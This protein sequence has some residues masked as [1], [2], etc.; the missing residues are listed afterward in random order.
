VTSAC[1]EKIPTAEKKIIPTLSSHS[2]RQRQIPA[3]DEGK[4]LIEIIIKNLEEIGNIVFRK[5]SL[6]NRRRPKLNFESR[7]F[8]R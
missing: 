7:P 1:R 4:T 3:V 5:R 6:R 2:Y 8:K